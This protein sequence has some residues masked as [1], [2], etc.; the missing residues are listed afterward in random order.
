MLLRAGAEIRPTDLKKERVE[1]GNCFIV[2][3]L[4]LTIRVSKRWGLG[5][6]RTDTLRWIETF[7]AK[8]NKNQTGGA[9]G[10][11]SRE[12]DPGDFGGEVMET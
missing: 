2:I 8:S 12:V 1:T 7:S 3:T 5:T 10:G 9:A 11:G 4:L 6:I